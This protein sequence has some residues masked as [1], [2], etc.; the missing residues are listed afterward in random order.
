MP[1]YLTDEEPYD[2]TIV[3][4]VDF[5][6]EVVLYEDDGTTLLDIDDTTWE[7]AGRR[8]AASCT[9]QWRVSSAGGDITVDE[10]GSTLSLLIPAADTAAITELA[11]EYDLVGTWPGPVVR[12]KLHG[13]YTL[14]LSPVKEP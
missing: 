13:R 10:A 9:D 3:R 1:E 2:I 8:D 14:R 7:F 5:E 11:G 12:Q 4:G 6:L